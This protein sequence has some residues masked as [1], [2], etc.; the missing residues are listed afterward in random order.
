MIVR[1]DRAHPPPLALEPDHVLVGERM[2]VVVN[3]PDG[4]PGRLG[5]R[6][7]AFR[8][9]SEHRIDQFDPFRGEYA[10]QLLD[11][12]EAQPF[13]AW[14]RVALAPLKPL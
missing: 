6:R 5:E 10:K 9:R 13:L 4:P 3:V 8:P 7:D 14:E 2:Q 11:G 12:R 1:N